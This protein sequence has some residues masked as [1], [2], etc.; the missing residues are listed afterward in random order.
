MMYALSSVEG[1]VASDPALV[2]CDPH[3]LS[4]EELLKYAL[5]VR[6]LYF[7]ETRV[8][9][10]NEEEL[11]ELK[12]EHNRVLSFGSSFS[13]SE[14]P[15]DWIRAHVDSPDQV[16]LGC[17]GERVKYPVIVAYYPGARYLTTTTKNRLIKGKNTPVLKM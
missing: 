12:K 2:E 10:K 8:S 13:G 16:S 3:S 11:I 4:G 14:F 15:R 9:Q 5:A 6:D 7:H 1:G 17:F